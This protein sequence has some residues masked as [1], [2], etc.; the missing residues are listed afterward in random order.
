L[1]SDK[2]IGLIEAILF[3]ENDIVTK[4]KLAKYSESTKEEV[5]EAIELLKMK[6]DENSHGITVNE[7][8]G[9][10]SI[11]VKKDI[12]PRI[13][14]IYGFK[15]KS[16]LS[17]STLTVLSIVAYKQPVTKLEIEQIRGVASDNA[18]RILLEKNLIEIVGRKE[19]LGRPLL[20]GTT[21]DFLKHFNLK[22]L[23]DL[24]QINE[25]KSEEFTLDEE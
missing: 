18:V 15:E 1:I 14:E 20:Y 7:I 24:P 23:K 3:Y 4:E 13:K 19:V 9:G 6:Y 8:G 16:K 10:Y 21:Q 22:D 11:Q 12:F 5:S 2:S 25:L 17:P